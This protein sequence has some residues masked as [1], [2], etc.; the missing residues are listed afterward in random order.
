VPGRFHGLVA[1]RLAVDL[2]DSLHR[3]V[4]GWPHSDRYVIGDQLLRA[5]YSVGANIA[6]ASGRWYVK[7]RQ[8]ILARG[9]LHEAEHWI[10]CA[11][12]QGLLPAGSARPIDEIARTLNG[13]INNVTKL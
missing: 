9:S 8:R 4:G 7:D 12:R 11:E 1:Y 2:A 6:E 13:L 5:A 10:I 3:S